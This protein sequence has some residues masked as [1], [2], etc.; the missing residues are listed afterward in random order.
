MVK[1]RVFA[2]QEVGGTTSTQD[3][4]RAAARSGAAEGFCCLALEQS[5]GRG[6]LGRPWLAPPGTALLASV[7][8]RVAEAAAPGVPFA[9]GL[10]LHDAL[11]ETAGLETKLKWPNDVLAGGGKLAGLLAEVCPEAATPGQVALIVGAGVNLT[12]P[13]FPD[14]VHGMSLHRLVAR[15]PDRRTLL[16]AWLQRLHSRTRQLEHAG[17]AEVLEP[18]RQ[19]A[20]GIGGPVRVTLPGGVVEGVAAGVRD[21]GALLVKTREGVIAVVAGDVN[22]LEPHESSTNMRLP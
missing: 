10:A 9:A 12:L 6:R 19:C 3:V 17:L 7:L 18:W 4:V 22:L 21:D 8:L 14:G 11:A 5:A 16:D 1:D 20:T 13:A 2:I 15:P